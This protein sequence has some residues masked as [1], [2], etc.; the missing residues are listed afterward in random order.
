MDSGR[1]QRV[2]MSPVCT[3]PLPNKGIEPTPYS[4]RSA[5]AFGRGSCRAFGI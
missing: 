3:V 2:G 4:L 5:S 1:V